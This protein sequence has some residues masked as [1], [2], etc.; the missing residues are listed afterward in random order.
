MACMKRTLVLFVG[1]QGSGKSTSATRLVHDLWATGRRAYK[2]KF[3]APLYEM[4]DAVRKVLQRYGVDEVKGIDGPLLQVLGTE[5]GRNTRGNDLWVRL[6]SGAVLDYW[7]SNPDGVV[8][9]DDCRFENEFKIFDD[10]KE[11]RVIKVLL[12]AER[13]VRKARAEKWRDNEEHISETALDGYGE[14]WFDVVCDTTAVSIG[15]VTKAVIDVV[16]RS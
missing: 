3:A 6:T 14:E 2:T 1:K 5:W 11:I 4:H 9:I 15:D 10:H 12:K 7:E 8:V 16:N 13:L